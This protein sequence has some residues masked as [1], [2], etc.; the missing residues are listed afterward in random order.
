MVGSIHPRGPLGVALVDMLEE[1]GALLSVEIAGVR[2][3][4]AGVQGL[5]DGELQLRPGRRLL[6]P[7]DHE[8]QLDPVQQLAGD[9]LDLG[10]LTGVSPS[11][12]LKKDEK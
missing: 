1:D 12:A 4:Q 2:L 7:V 10:A 3:R 5:L 8:Q 9:L 11:S 6:P